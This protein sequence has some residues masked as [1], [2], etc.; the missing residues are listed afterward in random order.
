MCLRAQGIDDND[1]VVDRVIRERGLSDNYGGVGRGRGIGD[2]SKVSETAT[3]A[4]RIQG[5]Q[6]ILRRCDDR[7]E[8]LAT[9]TEVLSEEDEPEV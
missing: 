1:G 7:P 2:A 8:E 5:R 9:M 4:S 6:R 3:E